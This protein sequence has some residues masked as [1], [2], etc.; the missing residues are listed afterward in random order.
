M[1]LHYADHAK[2]MLKKRTQLKPEV[3]IEARRIQVSTWNN[4]RRA[5]MRNAAT[6]PTFWLQ[7]SESLYNFKMLRKM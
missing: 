5:T 2:R 3:R 1:M 4:R 6:T 7:C